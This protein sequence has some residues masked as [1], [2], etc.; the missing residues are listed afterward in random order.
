MK[1]MIFACVAFAAFG[2]WA[3]DPSITDVNVSYDEDAR[4]VEIAYTLEHESAIVTLDILT[5]GVSVAVPG[6]AFDYISGDVHH[7]VAVGE[8]K[9]RWA[10]GNAI[11][12]V[13]IPSLNVSA[14]VFAWRL[15]E[16]PD[17]LIVDL[18]SSNSVEYVADTNHFMHGGVGS[19]LMRTRYMPMRLIPAAGQ[20]FTLGRDLSGDSLSHT[21]SEA[22]RTVT[23]PSDGNFYLA[24]FELTNGQ[25]FFAGD[26]W[27]YDNYALNEK[28]EYRPVRG[29]NRVQLWIN[30][31]NKTNA[32][33]IAYA[34][35]NGPGPD[36]QLARI[37]SWSALPFTLP[38]E[39][40]WE[41]AAC[42]G[43]DSSHW[44][45][46]SISMPAD[47][48]V[49][50]SVM[51]QL[52]L[53]SDNRDT[54]QEWNNNMAKSGAG[55]QCVG[56][57]APNGYGLYDMFGN[58][59]ELCLDNWYNDPSLA[60]SDGSPYARIFDGGAPDMSSVVKGGSLIEASG[61]CRTTSR[62]Y[63]LFGNGAKSQYPDQSIFD[64][65]I[66]ANLM[67]TTY[68]LVL[69]LRLYGPQP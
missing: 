37:R 64:N 66:A 13:D 54:S 44:G 14:E 4:T 55:S 39:A 3:A 33:N 24:L 5:N 35:P 9:I 17:Y 6:G 60:P 30:T 69:P 26:A 2:L 67:S 48:A 63:L 50:N 56:K 36:G 22:Q 52:G 65:E 61:R 15:D 12:D 47:V 34:Y 1:N 27:C 11:P 45:D 38:S 62:A 42:G 46:G 58:N 16:P 43:S 32:S 19:D 59:A 29:L 28:I 68:R 23:F 40:Q 21:P 18:A 25:M 7:A 20:T 41:F 57:Y 49:A 10:V 31:G 51:N 8:R 53:Y